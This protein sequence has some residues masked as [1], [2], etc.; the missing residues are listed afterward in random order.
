MHAAS[1]L[2]ALFA[3]A[4]AMLPGPFAGGQSAPGFYISGTIAS[5]ETKLPGVVITA[6][7]TATGKSTS[8]VSDDE[9]HYRLAVPGP[10]T[11]RVRAE[12][13]GFS[14]EERKLS[15]TDHEAETNFSLVLAPVEATNWQPQ[16]PRP[17]D[18]YGPPT[19]KSP[20]YPKQPVPLSADVPMDFTFV[21]G[22][23]AQPAAAG[24]SAGEQAPLRQSPVHFNVSYQEANSALDATPY[25]LHGL[26]AAKPE[27]AQN[28]FSAGLGATLPWGKKTATT[29]LYGSYTGNR[30]GNPFSGFATLPTAAMRAGDFSGL[31]AL[32]GSAGPPLTIYDPV[33]GAP[34]ASNQVPFDRMNPAALALLQYI[35]LPN[36][37]GT[38]QNFR[39]VTATHRRSDGF[40]LS[41]TRAPATP[42]G[43]NRNVA[44]QNNFSAGLGYHRSDAN[45]PNIFPSLGGNSKSHGWNGNLSYSLTKGFFANNFSLGFNATSSRTL[46]RFRDDAGA[47]LGI[48]GVSQDSFDW[49]LPAIELTQFTGLRDVIPTLRANRNFNFA[50]VQSWSRGKHN[51]KWGGEFR[52]LALDLHSND[53][54][55][56]SFLFTGFATAQFVDGIPV[57]G[58]GSDFADFLLGLPQKTHVQYSNGTFSF[59]GNAW[60]LYFVDDWRVAKNVS[61]NLGLRYEYVSPL[62]EAKNQLV[63]L[64]A[65]PDFSTV[66]AVRAGAIGSFTGR[67]PETIVAPD[68]NNFAP[69]LGI[70]WRAADRFIVRAGYSVD[71]DSSL[72]DWLATR[73]SLQPP[74]AVEQTRIATRGQLLTLQNGFPTLEANTVGNDFA[75]SRNLPLGYAQIWVLEVQNELPG[76]LAVITSYTGT[77]GSHLQ[78]LRAPNRTA[79]GLLLPNVAPF[80]W[81][82]ADGS[83]ILH[84]G[85]VRVQKRLASGLSFG[86]SYTFSRSIDNDPAL[87][88]DTQVAQ[89]DRNL[90]R[91]R[92]LSSFDQRHRL[93]VDYQYE[94]PF[95]RGKPWLNRSAIGNQLLGGWSFTGIINYSSGLPFTPHVVGGFADVEAG[96][97]G[98]LRADV[99]GQPVQLSQPSV[100]RFFNT[101]A[102]T[103]PPSGQYGDAGRNMIIGP[104]IFTFD[105]ALAKSITIAERHSL[106]FQAQASNL[107]NKPQFTQVDTNLNSSSYGQITSVGPMRAI[108]L[109]LLY[110]F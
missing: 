14:P 61:L 11:Y 83:S 73:L 79:T 19:G 86:A 91:E 110:A 77:K 80:Q 82:V 18:A 55:A 40:W 7:S 24:D 85:S 33:S 42:A 102:F 22:Q 35:P 20:G 69:R 74:F 63:T 54:A 108:Q 1:Q 104:R 75:V 32:P 90:N 44:V 109:R 58:T 29:S 64:D 105:A 53:D 101:A 107:L 16:A 100:D 30:S 50:D 5:G 94:L 28:T 39:F 103:A 47:N 49:G 3:I 106:Q 62:S 60:S 51:L 36:R 52:R 21:L 72:Y 17:T 66:A 59:H 56:G 98:A 43:S 34:F 9:G 97:Y 25:A 10:G 57:P 46:N 81:Q 93:R 95:G 31:P 45:L 13:F 78:M 38:S 67:Y 76:G 89:D 71:Y 23:L 88:D 12:L 4:F 99:T 41:L 26:A 68:R 65:P 6:E 8:T 2:L 70:A 27:Y 92:G 84:A 48:T 15:V 37:D 96:G 87:G